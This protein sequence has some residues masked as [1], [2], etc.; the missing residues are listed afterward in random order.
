[1]NGNQITISVNATDFD[2]LRKIARTRGQTVS[3]YVA[4]LVSSN[5]ANVTVAAATTA[6]N[7]LPEARVAAK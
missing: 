2:E 1:M 5:L 3:D 4:R 6:N 7:V